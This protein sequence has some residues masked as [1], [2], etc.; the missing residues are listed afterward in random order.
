MQSDG[1]SYSALSNSSSSSNGSGITNAFRQMQ[2]KCRNVELGRNDALKEVSEMKR[3]I[4]EQQRTESLMRSRT[5]SLT[6]ETLMNIKKSNEKIHTIK[7]NLIENLTEIDENSSKLQKTLFI[8]QNNLNNLEIDNNNYKNKL[9]SL[10]NIINDSNYE[11]NHINDRI[12]MINNKI[13]YKRNEIKT[14]EI[15]IKNQIIE[16]ENINFNSNI[17]LKNITIR[18]DA[19]YKYMK[20]LLNIN[21]DLNDAGT[22]TLSS[23]VKLS[24]R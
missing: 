1:N 12:N 13:I 10:N 2:H 23:V 15:N 8:K 9:I 17:N 11:Y 4:S 24:L 6:N 3:L 7:L 21:K 5:T 16:C 22:L 19:M 20:M 18:C 14:N